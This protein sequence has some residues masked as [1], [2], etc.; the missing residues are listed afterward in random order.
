MGYDIYSFHAS[1]KHYKTLQTPIEQRVEKVV[2]G[3][4]SSGV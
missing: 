2:G 1:K 3:F 4:W